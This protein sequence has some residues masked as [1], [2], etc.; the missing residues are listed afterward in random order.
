MKVVSWISTLLL[1]FYF[2]FPLGASNANKKSVSVYI[3]Q[4]MTGT[5]Q[6]SENSE[7][8]LILKGN[9]LNLVYFTDQP[10]RTTGE[11][12]L[13]QYF[14]SWQSNVKLKKY[15]PTAFLNFNTFQPDSKEGVTPDI[16]MLEEPQYDE[17]NDT[18]IFKVRPL[19]DQ[20]MQIGKLE[21][22]VIIYDPDE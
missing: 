20:P 4:S 5:I 14:K 13:S 18:L 12:S 7:Y 17:E 6:K 16:L 19:H 21:H 1:V 9:S 15:P 8:T 3:Q 10:H 2:T 11:K 22:V